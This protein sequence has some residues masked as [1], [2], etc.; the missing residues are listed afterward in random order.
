MATTAAPAEAAAAAAAAAQGSEGGAGQQAQ[1]AGGSQ[2]A[3]AAAQAPRK[4]KPPARDGWSVEWSGE[5]S[6]WYWWNPETKQSTWTDP[7]AP[8]ATAPAAAGGAAATAGAGAGDVVTDMRVVGM[9]PKHMTAQEMGAYFAQYGKVVNVQTAQDTY[10]CDA[11]FLLPLF[12]LPP[13]PLQ[14][15]DVRAGS[16]GSYVH[17]DRLR[18][19]AAWHGMTRSC[20]LSACARAEPP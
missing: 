12:L 17:G 2:A 4:P 6:E 9:F 14:V 13:S 15:G 3:A 20:A 10:G 11:P 18:W 16:T 5:Y 1:T 19:L 8:A 7:G